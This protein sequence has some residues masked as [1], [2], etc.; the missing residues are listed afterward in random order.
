MLDSHHMLV[1]E[2]AYMAGLGGRQRNSIRLYVIDTRRATD[3][4]SI[5]AL[6]PGNHTPAVKTLVA[7][8]A[9][10]QALSTLDNIEGMCWGPM[11][12][13]NKGQPGNRTL[14]F[15]SDDN[16]NPRQVTQLLAFE[17]LEQQP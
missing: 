5:A 4:S 8:L 7:D 9:S 17:F 13:D 11:L 6:Q 3:T 1:L 16:F 14:M 10:F 2:R 15:V 12:P